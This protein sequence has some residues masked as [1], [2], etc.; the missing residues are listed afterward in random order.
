VWKWN[1]LKNRELSDHTSRWNAVF[2]KIRPVSHPDKQGKMTKKAHCGLSVDTAFQFQ[3]E[4]RIFLI[5]KVCWSVANSIKNSFN[6]NHLT[7][8]FQSQVD[9]LGE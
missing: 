6:V 3:N 8:K 1:I 2:V 4:T 7:K 5:F 9:F